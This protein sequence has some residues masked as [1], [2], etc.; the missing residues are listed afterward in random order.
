MVQGRVAVV[1]QRWTWGE[2]AG[3]IGLLVTAPPFRGSEIEQQLLADLMAGMGRRTMLIYPFGGLEQ[4][5]RRAG[6]QHDGGVEQWQGRPRPA[7]LMPLPDGARLRPASRNDLSALTGLDARATGLSRGPMIAAWLDHAVNAIVLD[8]GSAVSGF[9]IMRRFGRGVYIGPVVA[10]DVEQ[11]QS[12]IAHL[13]SA[14]TGRFLRI[15]IRS[16]VLSGMRTWL[17][18]LGLSCVTTVPMMRHGPALE[19]DPRVRN[20]AIAAQAMA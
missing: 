16:D 9:A 13:C 5:A 8:Q 11:A 19:T 15:D 7:P 10:P 4:L 17:T 6:F 3:T 20:I 14:A 1:G 18:G 2:Q 12:M